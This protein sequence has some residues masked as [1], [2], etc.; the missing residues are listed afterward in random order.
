[1]SNTP[2]YHTDERGILVKCYH[3]CKTRIINKSFWVGVGVSF[4]GFTVGFPIEHFI[5]EKLWPFT[6][7]TKAMGL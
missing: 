1:M 6:L 7:L 5:W 3:E 4:L 2:H